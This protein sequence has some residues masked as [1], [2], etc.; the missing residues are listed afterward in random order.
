MDVEVL[1]RLIAA[2]E[3]RGVDYAIFGAVAMNLHGLVRVTED[4]DVF[5]APESS[6]IDRLR[7]ALMDVFDDPDIEQISTADLLGE[8]PSIRYAPPDES[9]YIDILTRIGDAFTYADLEIERLPV[10]GLTARVV[11]PRTLYRMKK[12]T[13]RPKDRMDAEALRHKFNLGD[14]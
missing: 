5:V 7:Q 4:V 14:D 6:N 8:Y 11:S 12:D 13:V 2:L 3:A 1:K 9:F 10:D